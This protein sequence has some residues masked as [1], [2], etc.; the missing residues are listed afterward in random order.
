MKGSDL[1]GFLLAPVFLYVGVVDLARFAGWDLLVGLVTILVALPLAEIVFPVK[2][3][4]F[5]PAWLLAFFTGVGLAVTNGAPSGGW[6]TL[7]AG[8]LLGAPFALLAGILLWRESKFATLLGVEGGLA[9]LVSLLA[10]SA[11][12]V[13]AGAESNATGWVLAFSHVNSEQVVD[14]SRWVQGGPGSAVPPLASLSDPVFLAFVLLAGLAILLALLERPRAIDPGPDPWDP[15][16]SRSSG[17]APLLVAGFAGLAFEL[18]AAVEPK[19]ALLGA[20]IGVVDALAAIVAFGV[21]S[22]RIRSS[23]RRSTPE[24]A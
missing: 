6:A 12:A 17:I 2:G 19:Y 7:A 8:V 14:L 16:F 11:F 21:F 24:R 10:S 15:Q 22:G 18:T 20:A 23:Q 13:E 5:I 4:T 3:F 1:R 9:A